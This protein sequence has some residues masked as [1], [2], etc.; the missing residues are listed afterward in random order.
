VFTAI[1]DI[2]AGEEIT[3]NYTGTVKDQSRLNFEVIET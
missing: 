2:K 1:R 3:V